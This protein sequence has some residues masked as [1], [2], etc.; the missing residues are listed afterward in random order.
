MSLIHPEDEPLWEA[1]TAA[2]VADEEVLAL[3]FADAYDQKIS[4]E[5]EVV[6]RG[7]LSEEELAML[8]SKNAGTEAVDPAN[9][10]LTQ[11]LMARIPARLVLKYHILPWADDGDTLFVACV[12]PLRPHLQETLKNL[13][14]REVQLLAAPASRLGES[15]RLA[16]GEVESRSD[17]SDFEVVRDDDEDED[18]DEEGRSDSA[19]AL[20]VE[21]II[22][23]AIRE[24]T[25]DIH[26]EPF[27]HETQ[28]RMRIDGTLVETHRQP[29][30][31]HNSICSRVKVLAGLNVAESRLPQDGRIE[32]RFEGRSVDL[33]ISTLPVRHGEMICIRVLDR[34]GSVLSLDRIGLPEE[35]VAGIRRQANRPS[36]IF[37]VTGPTGSGKSTTL[38]AALCELNVSTEKILTAEDPIEY[39]ID[40]IVQVQVHEA[41]GLGYSRLIRAFLRQDPDRIMIGEIRDTETA[42][43]AIQAALTGHMVY[44]TLHTNDAPGAVARLL[45]MG[46]EPFL[47][48]AAMNGVLGQRLLRKICDGCKASYKPEKTEVD[49]LGLGQNEVEAGFFYGRGCAKCNMTGYRGRVPIQ[50]L[51]EFTPEIKTLVLRRAPTSTIRQQA[52]RQGMVPMRLQGARLVVTGLTTAEEVLKYT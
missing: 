36:G 9:A 49:A 31:L 46:V 14:K 38:Y 52:V 39:E 50:E 32:F 28:V 17:L 15:I 4:P 13:L 20:L 1:L 2:H 8:L 10:S 19:I 16:Y 21:S 37:I 34:S 23:Q 45:D 6:D 44:S 18:E 40:G 3:A 29:R 7:L 42:A 22:S 43:M 12:N 25:S 11:D 35:L 27:E 26:I 5:E 24:R 30:L 51:L 41:I 48:A 33:R 47:I